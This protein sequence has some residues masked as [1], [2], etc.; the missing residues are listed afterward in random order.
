MLQLVTLRRSSDQLAALSTLADYDPELAGRWAQV[1][2][3]P[4][5]GLTL[6]DFD[7]ALCQVRASV[8]SRELDA[9]EEW[10]NTY[11]SFQNKAAKAAGR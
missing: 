4:C 3:H 1:L 9:F 5:P 6:A 7:D 2:A 10:N 11:G 8:S